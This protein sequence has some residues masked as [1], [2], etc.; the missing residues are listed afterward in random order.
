MYGGRLPLESTDIETPKSNRRDKGGTRKERGSRDSNWQTG[1]APVR[2]CDFVPRGTR[3]QD[4]DNTRRVHTTI[5]RRGSYP[6]VAVAADGQERREISG[7]RKGRRL[8]YVTG[9][10]RRR[11]IPLAIR[12]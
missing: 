3:M 7:G 5:N 8:P 12:P 1:S 11:A 9:S 10:A 6:L 4:D 2:Y